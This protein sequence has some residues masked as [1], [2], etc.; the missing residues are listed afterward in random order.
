[1]QTLARELKELCA[2]LGGRVG[3]AARDLRSGAEVM[4]HA[5]EPY[6]LASVFKIP[7]MVEVLRRADAGD[8]SLDEEIELREEDKS[9]GGILLHLHDGLRLT[10]RDL[11][12]F[13]I[14]QS[15]NIATDLLW[16][17]VG[18]ESVNR[19]MHALGLGDIDCYIPDREF[20]LIEVGAPV[21][22]RGLTAAQV[23]ERVR[24]AR[25]EGRLAELYAALL[26]ESR[27]LDGAAFQRLYDER[28]GLDGSKGF[29]HSFVI[30]QALDNTGSPASMLEL[31]AMIA[32]D[33]CAAPASCRLMEQILL[34]QEWRERIPAGLPAGL[35]VA[36]KTGSVAGTINDA[37]IV[38]RADGSALVIVVF[39]RGL[40][41]AAEA[42][43]EPV[44]AAVAGTIW[45]HLG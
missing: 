31:L 4:L 12:Y 27:D 13:M 17:R 41:Q 9:P 32:E 16:R 3:V 1:M 36:N 42:H 26:D 25:D 35:H 6:P 8:L 21:S 19:T 39:T 30:D 43:A 45:R 11:L 24:A 37:A 14:T 23:V 22:W 40:D 10:V 28:F 15:D 5:H 20:F 2:P 18:L 7:V 38:R 29:D 34:R 44:I 33:R